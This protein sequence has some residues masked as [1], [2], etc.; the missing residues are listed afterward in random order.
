MDAQCG[1]CNQ[2]GFMGCLFCVGAYYPDFLCSIYFLYG[3]FI[4][5]MCL[6]YY[7]NST[8]NSTKH[9]HKLYTMLVWLP[10][11]QGLRVKFKHP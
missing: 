3:I 7:S 4:Y 10:S 2:N 11:N 5:G 9:M 8:A 1:C 6:S